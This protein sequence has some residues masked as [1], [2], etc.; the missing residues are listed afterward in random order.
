LFIRVS[1]EPFIDGAPGDARELDLQAQIASATCAIPIVGGRGA[2]IFHEYASPRRA[3]MDNPLYVMAFITAMFAAIYLLGR[4][5]RMRARGR[6]QCPERHADVDV[7][8]ERAFG[9]SWGPGRKLEV[10][11]CTAFERPDHVDCDRACL[12]SS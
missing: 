12:R 10:L 6:L 11:R 2:V 1:G 8:F 4:L 3:L 9:P 7:D 5:S